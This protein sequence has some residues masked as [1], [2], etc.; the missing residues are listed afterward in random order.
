MKKFWYWTLFGLETA[1]MLFI[2]YMALPLYRRLLRGPGGERPGASLLLPGV[3]VVIVMQIGYWIMRRIRPSIARRRSPFVAHLLLF[4]ARLG[5]IFTGAF[6]S[7]MLLNRS[8]DTSMSVPGVLV[9]LAVAFAQ[10]CYVR[11]LET[12]ARKFEDPA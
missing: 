8:A 2:L 1:G 3:C 10:F 6:L 12:L 7:L 9:L 4:L 11:E 5:F